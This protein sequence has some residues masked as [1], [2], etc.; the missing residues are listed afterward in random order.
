[1]FNWAVLLK[2]LQKMV[3][4]ATGASDLMQRVK[5]EGHF[6]KWP[7]APWTSFISDLEADSK[8]A[9]SNLQITQT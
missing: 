5:E 3:S 4:R 6:L 9:S 1:M 7:K 8:H 2:A